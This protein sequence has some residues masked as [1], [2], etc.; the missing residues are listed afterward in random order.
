[1]EF[2]FEF[3]AAKSEANKIKHGINL[4]EAQQ[5]WNDPDLIAGPGDSSTESRWLAVGMISGT[6]WT[7]CFTH[8]QQKVRLIECR[9]AR[10]EERDNYESGK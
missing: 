6:Y 5:L 3:D 4:I 8:R 2:E 10:R 7:V 9:R 1:V